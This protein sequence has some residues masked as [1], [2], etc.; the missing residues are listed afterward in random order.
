MDENLHYLLHEDLEG[1]FDAPANGP[2][3]GDAVGASNPSAQKRATASVPA[4]SSEGNDACANDSVSKD[5]L[6]ADSESIGADLT[7]ADLTSADLAS[8][9]QAI[10]ALI[11]RLADPKVLQALSRLLGAR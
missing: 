2:R 10:D 6:H 11:Q 7:S 5:S 3:G 4:A 1:L 9:E 8:V